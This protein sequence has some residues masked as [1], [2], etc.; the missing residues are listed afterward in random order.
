MTK[1]LMIY[2]QCQQNLYLN[3]KDL[4]F[5]GRM[6]NVKQKFYFVTIK[7]VEHVSYDI[8]NKR[9]KIHGNSLKYYSKQIQAQ[10]IE[11]FVPIS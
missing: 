1:Y 11:A 5:I 2:K 8:Q 9:E 7:D 4:Y 6:L 3:R 10:K